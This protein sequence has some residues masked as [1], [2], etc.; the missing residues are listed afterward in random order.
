MNLIDF[1]KKSCAWALSIV[2][3]I[4]TFVPETFFEKNKLLSNASSEANVILNRVIVFLAMLILSAIINTLYLVFRNS[5]CIKG[6]NFSIRIIY[7]DLFKIC[8]SKKVIN[9]DE[10]FTTSVGDS[11]ADIKPNSICGQYLQKSQINDQEMQGLI[12]TA[13][14]KPA[15][16]KSKYQ[17]KVRYDPGILIPNGDYLLMAFAK[18][19]NNGLGRMSLGEYLEC[20]SKL[21][22]EID[23]HYGQK[24]VCIPI[25]GSGITRMGDGFL[26]QQKLLD[27]IIMSYKL[28]PHKIKPPYQLNIVCKNRKDVSL[29]KIGKSI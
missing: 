10:C 25:L 12:E 26:T 4:F 20:L 5:I 27:I 24:D 13:K 17:S 9:F 1:F 23:K 29:N 16:G 6:N 19:D 14:I 7:G 11:P 28:S 3:V 22:E 2:T 21:W 15:R 18:L 8:D